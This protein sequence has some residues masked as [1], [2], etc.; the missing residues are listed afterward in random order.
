[1]PRKVRDPAMPVYVADWFASE[2]IILMTLEQEAGYMRLLMHSWASGDCTIP[3]DDEKLAALSRLGPKWLEGSGAVIRRCF[4]RKRA[5]GERR[6]W[7]EKL[8]ELWKERR[9]YVE[10][11]RQAGLKSAKARGYAG[12]VR[13]TDVATERQ[14]N[15]QR[16][17][18]SSS[19]SS[20]SSSSSKSIIDFLLTRVS[21]KTMADIGELLAWIDEACEA[22]G[23]TDSE[24]VRR[25]VVALWVRAKRKGKKSPAALFVSLVRDG[26]WDHPSDS[27]TEAAIAEIDEHRRRSAV[28]DPAVIKLA[29][30]KALPPQE[31]EAD[32]HASLLR[33]AQALVRVNGGGR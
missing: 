18:N 17:G 2:S 9:E 13:S 21:P 27:D 8:S 1:M 22:G 12:N 19:S 31:S 15:P 26:K 10:Q 6:L 20:L 3:D 33:Q 25:S 32:R 14:Q 16:K 24:Y 29:D 28:T 7:N 4:R 5:R 30:A 11:C 23:I